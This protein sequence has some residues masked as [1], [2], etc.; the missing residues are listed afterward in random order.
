MGQ[1][2]DRKE[3]IYQKKNIADKTGNSKIRLIDEFLSYLLIFI[4]S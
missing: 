4:Q 2:V 1:L 3:D